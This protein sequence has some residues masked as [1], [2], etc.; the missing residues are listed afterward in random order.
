MY[1]REKK[2]RNKSTWSK[3]LGIRLV[4]SWKDIKSSKVYD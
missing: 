4:H 1:E 2:S 3:I